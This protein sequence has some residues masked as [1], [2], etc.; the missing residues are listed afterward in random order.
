MS[1]E[2]SG[3]AG[4][5]GAGIPNLLGLSALQLLPLLN[6]QSLGN[7]LTFN[8]NGAG[9]AASRQAESPVPARVTTA[10]IYKY[11]VKIFN[12]ASSATESPKFIV[13]QLYNFQGKFVDL[14]ALKAKIITSFY[15]DVCSVKEISAVGYFEGKQK[16]WLCDDNDIQMMYKVFSG[17]NCEIPLWCERLV[18]K[19]STGSINNKRVPSK[20]DRHEEEVSDIF[21]D[22]KTKH[23]EMELPKLR[24]WARM[25]ANGVHESTEEPP[26]V[27]MIT[28]TVPKRAKRESLHDVVVDAAKAM[29]QAFTGSP[30][31][32]QPVIV[33]NSSA[34]ACTTAVTQPVVTTSTAT[35]AAIS[36]SRLA[37]VRMKHYEQL[38]YL[39]KMFDDHILSEEEFLEQKGKIMDSLRLL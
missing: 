25:I 22:L 15:T 39:H 11:N 8:L 4:S 29:A 21:E 20:R 23:K 31:T 28:G 27:P 17:T 34:A 7:Q 1:K 26:N 3:K 32:S 12:P 5:A 16:R 10:R 35:S 6:N 14:A 13:R 9:S 38:R 19:E 2:A 37:D 24:L 18:D 33:H 30:A 36:P